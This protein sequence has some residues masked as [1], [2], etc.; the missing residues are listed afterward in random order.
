M[1]VATERRLLEEL[2]V[3]VELEYVYKFR[4]QVSFGD[5][6]SEHELCSVYLG[7]CVQDIRPNITEIE[8]IRF[9]SVEEL[10]AEIEADKGRFTPWLKQEW[11]RLNGEHA[12]V[13]GRY[14]GTN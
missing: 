2:G 9:I 7:R 5:Q 10:A 8:A 11:D 1:P 4:Y 12:D 13:L 6:G 14:L 3:A